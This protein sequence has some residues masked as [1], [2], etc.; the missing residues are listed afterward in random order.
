ME[1]CDLKIKKN[2]DAFYIQTWKDT[3]IIKSK[4]DNIFNMLFFVKGENKI[5]IPICLHLHKETL[6]T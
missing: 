2:E 1:S 4:A 6:N 3:V 5:Y